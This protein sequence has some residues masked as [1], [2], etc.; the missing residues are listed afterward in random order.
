MFF[1][2][3][4]LFFY[5]FFWKL[6]KN[7]KNLCSQRN[8]PLVVKLCQHSKHWGRHLRGFPNV[9]PLSPHR[10]IHLH[11]N[12]PSVRPICVS[13]Y[14]TAF[15]WF[16]S[17]PEGNTIE[18]VEGPSFHLTNSSMALCYPGKK[19]KM[20][21]DTWLFSRLGIV[22]ILASGFLVPRAIW[23]SSINA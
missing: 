14:H 6:K 4:M 2:P 3:G 13:S 11:V 17:Q 12:T 1:L 22:G 9:C 8:N 23:L 19:S 20:Q 10:S 16:E 5:W 15:S 21:N 7:K 18:F